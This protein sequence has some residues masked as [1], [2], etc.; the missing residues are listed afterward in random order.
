MTT[1]ATAP[2]LA[3]LPPESVA[4]VRAAVAHAPPLTDG[5]RQRLRLLFRTATPTDP[6]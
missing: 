6:R 3:N 1:A 4:V 2:W 5:Q